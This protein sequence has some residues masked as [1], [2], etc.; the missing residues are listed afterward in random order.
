MTMYDINLGS[1]SP[2]L[3]RQA[4]LYSPVFAIFALFILLAAAPAVLAAGP[5]CSLPGVTVMRDQT[6][7]ST[8][9]LPSH[10]IQSFSIAEPSDLTGQS[11]YTIKVAD[12]SLLPPNTEWIVDW[13]NYYAMTFYFITMNTFDPTRGPVFTYG[14]YEC[15]VSLCQSVTDGEADAGE[16][17]PDG[18]IRITI[19]NSKLGNQPGQIIGSYQGAVRLFHHPT[20]GIGGD[21]DNMFGASSDYTF[22]GNA[23]CGVGGLPTA[24][25]TNLI[26]ISPNNN[27]AKKSLVTLVWDDNAD[28]EQVYH[29]ERSTTPYDIMFVQI[30]TV[31]ANSTSYEDRTVQRGTTYYYR[32]RASNPGGYSAY[33][34]TVS[35][36]VK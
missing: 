31:E 33:S 22:V 32:V 24:A 3:L 19:S 18:T 36:Y 9:T 8:D 13:R 16:Y 27:G 25:P 29:I 23:S 35:V 34:N 14:H 5:S 17:L 6:G 28:N 7:D 26:A 4:Q 1:V 2:G 15:S 21:F 10:D 30:G 11:V 12:L 20:P